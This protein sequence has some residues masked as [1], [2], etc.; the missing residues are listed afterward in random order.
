MR[1][2]AVLAAGLALTFAAIGV[3]LLRSPPRVLGANG[4][5]AFEHKVWH[6]RRGL[7]QANEKLPRGT[8]A[9]RFYGRALAGPRMTLTAREGN[10]VIAEGAQAAGWSGV[11]VTIPLT[12]TVRASS[13]VE[14]C[15]RVG[16]R[17][18]L[19]G[20][21][22]KKAAAG[23]SAISEGKQLG[24][25]VRMEYLAAGNH[26]YWS[27]LLPTARRLGLGHAGSGTA[28]VLLLLVM[29]AAATVLGSWFIVRDLR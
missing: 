28:I 19:W 6:E 14:L 18:G 22:G 9:I 27:M 21:Q 10:R 7:C 12:H 16:G 20:V 13:H 1:I 17:N 29:T 23:R 4:V 5:S 8:S 24:L 25:R 3:A 15:V 2:P 26:S 11:N